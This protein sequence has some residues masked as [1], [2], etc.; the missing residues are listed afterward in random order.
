MNLYLIRH[1]ET[2]LSEERRFCGSTD[3][4]LSTTGVSNV[5]KLAH[6]LAAHQPLP[7]IVFTS[8]L[9]RARRTAELLEPLWPAA[10]VQVEPRVAETDF[11]AWEGWS[12]DQI[13]QE[14]PARFARW[15][16]DPLSFQPP[17]GE[18]VAELLVRVESFLN[19]LLARP[20]DK[21]VAIVC[22]GGVIRAFLLVALGLPA[23]LF[24]HFNPPWASVSLLQ[25]SDPIRRLHFLGQRG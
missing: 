6:W 24:W 18:S 1:G 14:D 7:D 22:H 19:E 20:A 16:A 5:E 2:R 23:H 17:G 12:G 13:Q 10:T 25:M 9:Q 3:P 4:P 21:N 15:M 11:G 8:P